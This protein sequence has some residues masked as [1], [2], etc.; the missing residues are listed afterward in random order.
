MQQYT[1]KGLPVQL[2]HDP[3]DTGTQ[4]IILEDVNS[5]HNIT[6]R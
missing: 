5:L 3:F 2:H 4:H 1:V 6:I